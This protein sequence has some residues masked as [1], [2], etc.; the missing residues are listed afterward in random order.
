MRPG[1]PFQKPPAV[2]FSVI[3][4]TPARDTL[5]D[6]PDRSVQATAEPP[7]GR[8]LPFLPELF[9]VCT[10]RHSAFRA[11]ARDGTRRM[12]H[13]ALPTLV[14]GRDGS[15]AGAVHVAALPVR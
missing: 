14:R 3:P 12:A 10:H 15:G 11:L 4:S 7:A 5:P 13:P 2:P 6:F 1:N 9:D 8:T